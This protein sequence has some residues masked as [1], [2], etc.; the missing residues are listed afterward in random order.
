MT[1]PPNHL[2]VRLR[3]PFWVVLA[4]PVA[5][6]PLFLWLTMRNRVPPEGLEHQ[7]IHRPSIGFPIKDGDWVG[8]G[9]DLGYVAF[10]DAQTPPTMGKYYRV[11]YSLKREGITDYSSSSERPLSRNGA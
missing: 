8:P 4:L 6:A 9:G 2:R 1:H 5:A 7:W 10:G 3:F 11:I